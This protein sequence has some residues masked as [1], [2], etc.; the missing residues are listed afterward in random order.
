[1]FVLDRI[2]SQELTSRS[3]SSFGTQPPC[4]IN[5]LQKKSKGGKKCMEAGDETTLSAGAV[6]GLMIDTAMY[7]VDSIMQVKCSIRLSR[8]F[9][10]CSCS[11]PWPISA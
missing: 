5:V 3:W 8:C 11:S 2:G 6:T 1:M 10:P 9:P 4:R 7:L